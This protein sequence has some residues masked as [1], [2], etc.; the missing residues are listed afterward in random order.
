MREAYEA[1]SADP[2]LARALARLVIGSAPAEAA[3]LHLDEASSTIDEQAAFAASMAA[4]LLRRAGEKALDA[5][6]GYLPALERKRRELC[7][8]EDGSAIASAHE[9]IAEAC[10][11]PSWAAGHWVRA[12]LARA[13]DEPAEAQRHLERAKDLCAD[14]PLLH[15]LLVRLEAASAAERAAMLEA[16]AAN[17]DP[18]AAR[19]ARR[20]A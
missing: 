1:S 7:G 13:A 11:D 12:A 20:R 9:A 17:L 16:S 2:L 14:D 8:S 6:P 19:A 18:A 3:K 15:D 4:E 10:I 5:T